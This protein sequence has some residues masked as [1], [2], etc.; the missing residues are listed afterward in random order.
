M[1]LIKSYVDVLEQE[2]GIEGMFKHIEKIGRLSH[3]SENKI[4]D[5]SYENFIS[6]MKKCG[7]YAVF[8]MGTVYLKINIFQLGI[9]KKLLRHP[10]TKVCFNKMSAYITTDYR[11]ILQEKLEKEMYKYWCEP[12]I[13]HYRKVT[14]HF[15]CSRAISHELVRHASLRPMQ[16]STRYCN[17]SSDKFNNELTFIIPEWVYDLQKKLADTV[18]PL[19]GEDRHYLLDL[20]GEK[21]WSALCTIDR[22]VASRDNLYRQIEKE[23]LFEINTDC[24]YSLR[25]ED[26]RGILPHDLKTELYMCGYLCDWNYKPKTQERT[27]FFYLRSDKS[28]HPDIRVLSQRLEKIFESLYGNLK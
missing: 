7:H 1:K 28:A 22:T 19:T 17:Y 8:N 26:A 5:S 13:Y 11:V 24:S 25:P 4:S 23:Y 6:L 20:K 9:L 3:K 27:G 2:P 14:A 10:Y 12:T 21:L 15:I 16:E 18:D